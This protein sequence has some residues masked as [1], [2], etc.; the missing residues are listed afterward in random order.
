VS[1]KG[2]KSSL[3]AVQVFEGIGIGSRKVG[4]EAVQVFEGIGIGS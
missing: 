3:E 2:V 4:L 1:V